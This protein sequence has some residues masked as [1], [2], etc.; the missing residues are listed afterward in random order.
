MSPNYTVRD[1][2]TYGGFIAGIA[3]FM[4]STPAWDVPH[5]IRLLCG[6]VVGLTV[7]TI[8][9][10]IHDKMNAHFSDRPPDD[11]PWEPR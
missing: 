6:A 4:V 9:G 1:L 10:R 5:L 2:F 8:S 3:V 7:G 11:D